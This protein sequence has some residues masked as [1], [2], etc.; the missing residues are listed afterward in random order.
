MAAK[1]FG[2]SAKYETVKHGSFTLVKRSEKYDGKTFDKFVGS[3][4][5][6]N[7][8]TIII[9][10]NVDGEELKTYEG[11]GK[12]EGKTLTSGYATQI[13]EKRK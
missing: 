9:S 3:I 10:L 6:D 7:G 1:K 4:P 5:L 11:K 8:Q 12:L 13:R 2:S